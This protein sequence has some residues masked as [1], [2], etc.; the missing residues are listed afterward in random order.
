IDPSNY[1][2]SL[3]EA[4]EEKNLL[5]D[6]DIERLQLECLDL[7]REKAERYSGRGS[8]SLRIETA[9]K[10]METVLYTLGLCLKTYPHPDDAVAALKAVSVR[11]L[12][13]RGR[14]RIDTLIAESKLIHR[15]LCAQMI[16]TKNVYYR[17]VIETDLPIIFEK[18]I[19]DYAAK[20]LPVELDYPVFNPLTES[21]GV[22]FVKAFTEAFYYE[23]WFCSLFRAQDVHHLL[24]GFAAD[25]DEQLMSVYA[26]VLTTALTC[27]A[28]GSDCRK[29]DLT[30]QDVDRVS[31]ALCAA[32]NEM[33]AAM[34]SDAAQELKT[35]LDIPD[36]L[37]A[38]VKRSVPIVAR[39][40]SE[41]IH[42]NA[43]NRVLCPPDFPEQN[44]TVVFSF[45]TKMPNTQYRAVLESVIQSPTSQAKLDVIRR[46]VHSLGDLDDILLDAD[47]TEQEIQD[48][49]RILNAA[50][51]AALNK[52]YRVRKESEAFSM[53]EAEQILRANLMRYTSSLSPEQQEMIRRIEEAMQ[54][55]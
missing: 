43:I 31:S 21:V 34:L 33:I 35:Q 25:Y 40:L 19:A 39:N 42:E 22:S 46:Y 38:Y 8:S 52:R 53:R 16:D 49:L 10:I 55:E 50:E 48:I 27:A 11:E 17:N 3:I 32:D 26:P 29:L 23:N 24:C 30:Q 9:Q 41:A 4:S 15:R 20:E 7:L 47:L 51:L 36:S 45:G 37:F 54:E 14:H 13:K 1:F 2:E 18:Y 28:I 6:S 5:D 44:A 12:Y